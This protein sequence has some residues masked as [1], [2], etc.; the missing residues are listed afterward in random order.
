MSKDFIKVTV[1]GDI[2]TR[3][4]L[5]SIDND[6]F[7]RSADPPWNLDTDLLTGWMP[8][9]ASESTRENSFTEHFR[10]VLFHN[11]NKYIR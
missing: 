5:H 9:N 1:P 2:S 3:L 8:L 7:T 6:S 10:T 11:G 4:S